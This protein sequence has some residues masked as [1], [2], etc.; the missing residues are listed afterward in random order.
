MQ[1]LREYAEECGVVYRFVI[2]R[3]LDGCREYGFVY[4]VEFVVRRV[5]AAA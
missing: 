3:R 5:A 2:C 1:L 4:R